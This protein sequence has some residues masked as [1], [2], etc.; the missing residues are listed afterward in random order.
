MTPLVKTKL[1]RDAANI[2]RSNLSNLRQDERRYHLTRLDLLQTML[3][4]CHVNCRSRLTAIGPGSLVVTKA[5]AGGGDD[6]RSAV[7]L[8]FRVRFKNLRSPA[9]TQEK[10]HQVHDN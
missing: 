1:E 3:V 9:L 6:V 7:D 5:G 4:Q 10:P 2:S 8:H